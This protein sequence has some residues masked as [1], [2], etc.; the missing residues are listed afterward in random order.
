ITWEDPPAQARRICR[1][2]PVRHACLE[3]AVR[4]GEPDGV[5]GGAT[6]AERRLMRAGRTA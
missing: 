2:C 5:W 6:P 1:A 4:T 3:W